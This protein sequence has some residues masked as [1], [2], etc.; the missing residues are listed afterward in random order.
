[1]YVIDDTDFNFSHLSANHPH[2]VRSS[3][4][5]SGLTF[6]II[7]AS[8]LSCVSLSMSVSAYRIYVVTQTEPNNPQVERSDFGKNLEEKFAAARYRTPHIHATHP[9]RSHCP[10]AHPRVVSWQL[11]HGHRDWPPPPCSSTRRPSTVASGSPQ[12]RRAPSRCGAPPG[13]AAAGCAWRAA[14]GGRA[15]PS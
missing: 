7:N 13:C 4:T 6:S 1:M 14:P 5:Y 12:V 9:P 2:H 8:A 10:H 11:Q 15:R 3:V